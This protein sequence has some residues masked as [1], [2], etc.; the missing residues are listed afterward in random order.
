MIS[1]IIKDEVYVMWMTQT[2]ALITI[3][4]IP[5]TR[6]IRRNITRSHVVTKMQS[7]GNIMTSDNMSSNHPSRG[8]I[9]DIFYRK[10]E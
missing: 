5:G 4:Y 1:R 7:E 3:I 2:E 6:V 8:Y 10:Y 9:N